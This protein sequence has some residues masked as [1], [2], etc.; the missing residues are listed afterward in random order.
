MIQDD[1]QVP[2]FYTHV[3]DMCLHNN[4][5]VSKLDLY[6]KSNLQVNLR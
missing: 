2:H 4:D 6:D 1:L 5:I 3:V